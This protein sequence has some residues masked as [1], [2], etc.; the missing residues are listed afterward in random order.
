MLQLGSSKPWQDAMEQITGQRNMSAKA[1]M[2]YFQPLV[3]WLKEQNKE[4]DEEIGWGEEC[5]S[6]VA[7]KTDLGEAQDFLNAF[8]AKAQ[9]AYYDDNVAEW[10]FAANITDYNQKKQVNVLVCAFVN[11]ST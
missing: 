2:N 6:P 7:F 9:V 11:L 8:N 10:N 5:P 1:L 4:T 3:D